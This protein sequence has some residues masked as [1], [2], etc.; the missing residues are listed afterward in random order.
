MKGKNYHIKEEE[1][2]NKKADQSS[3]TFVGSAESS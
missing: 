3:N 2:E 1:I